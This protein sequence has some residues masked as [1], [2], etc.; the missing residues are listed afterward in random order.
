MFET[1]D[2]AQLTTFG[3]KLDSWA[4]TFFGSSTIRQPYDSLIKQ[5]DNFQKQIE[6][7]LYTVCYVLYI[8]VC[9]LAK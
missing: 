8:H 2:F 5:S 4:R 3:S 6:I 9:S 1:K 7:L